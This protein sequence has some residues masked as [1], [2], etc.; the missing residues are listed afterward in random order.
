MSFI[1]GQ[2]NRLP[3]PGR[4]SW[5]GVRKQISGKPALAANQRR[6]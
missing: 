3:A 4:S 5:G 2:C 1:G 6:S